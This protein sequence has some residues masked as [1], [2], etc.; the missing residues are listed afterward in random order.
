MPA[1]TG[2]P[3]KEFSVPNSGGLKIALSVRRVISNGGDGGLP[4]ERARS[5]F[6]S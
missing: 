2:H 4:K 3:P 5:L 1:D 6:F